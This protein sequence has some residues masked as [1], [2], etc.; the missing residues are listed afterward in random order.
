MSQDEKVSQMTP[1]EREKFLLWKYREL[2][3][4]NQIDR[5]TD[6]YTTVKKLMQKS[7]EKILQVLKCEYAAFLIGEADQRSDRGFFQKSST[8]T[9]EAMDEA[10]HRQLKKFLSEPRMFELVPE[11]HPALVQAGLRNFLLF[12]MVITSEIAGVFLLANFPAEFGKREVR[13]MKVI[14]SQLDN[15]VIF[16][17]FQEEHQRTRDDLTQRGREIS[18]LYEM[19]LNLGLGYDFETLAEKVL[20]GAM[21]LAGVDRSSVMLFDPVLNE[22]VTNV[23]VGEK[24]K[25]RLV[26]LKPGKGI[27]GMAFLSGKPILAPA[28]CEDPRFVPFDFSGIKVKKI[29]SLLS[30]PMISGEKTLGVLNFVVLSKKRRLSQQDVETLTVAGNLVTLA[31]QRQQFYQ[32]S[33]KDELTG[34]YSFRYFKERLREEVTRARRY[35]MA[36]SLVIF[37]LDHFK[38]VNDTYGHPFGNV[39]LKAVAEILKGSVRQDVDLPARFGG[40]EMALIL[41]HTNIEGAGI[42]SE[43][44]R[45]RVESLPL[46]FEGKPVQVTI[47]GG[48]SG[49]SQPEDTAENVLERAD[50]ALYK[51]KEAGRN[52]IITA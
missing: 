7:L 43:R 46:E 42:L 39:V 17:R 30:I 26:K 11:P 22:L 45:Q 9:T 24:Q 40:E 5:L 23:V 31:L 35:K 38:A 27:A 33:I 8:S 3:L 25:I 44:I 18:V 1:E 36:G 50:V 28:G 6:R 51:A 19:S 10:T 21:S 12:P 49:F 48:V 2:R 47:S 52:R 4:I 20:E 14:C 41:P 29:Q 34:L 37:D 13:L 15:A 32:M 16:A